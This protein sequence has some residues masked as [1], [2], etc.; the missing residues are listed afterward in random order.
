MNVLMV[1]SWYT[2]KNSKKITEGIFHYEQAISLQKYCNVAIYW[3]F[4][5]ENLHV[6]KDEEF[7]LLTYRSGYRHRRGISRWDILKNYRKVIREYKPDVIHAQV[8]GSAGK[9]S[10]IISKLHDIP[11]V[12]TEHAPLEMMDLNS[13]KYRIILKYIYSQS[14]K[15]ICVSDYLNKQLSTKFITCQF[16]TIFNPI[17]DCFINVPVSRRRL[18]QKIVCGVVAQLYDKDI[19]G[20][21]FLLPAIRNLIDNN[22]DIVLNIIGGGKYL[23]YYI[24]LSKKLCLNNAVIFHGDCPKETVVNIITQ[25]DFMISASLFESAG[26][27]IEESLALGKPMVVTKSGGGDSLVDDTNAIVVEKGSVDAL[28]NGIKDMINNYSR[29]DQEA[30]AKNAR[31]K[32]SMKRIT[33]QYISIYRDCVTEK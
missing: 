26:V 8:A 17:A 11:V 33:E 4:D 25:M 5:G 32:F 23:D 1:V 2:S 28:A 15:N 14:Y 18:N 31:E 12:I 10:I 21:Q 30:I 6:V 7:G 9:Y 24:E 20:L 22:V 3:P 27:N 16:L 13:W 19:K 29:F